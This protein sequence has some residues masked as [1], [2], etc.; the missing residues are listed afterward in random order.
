MDIIARNKTG[1]ISQL[2]LLQE[3]VKRKGFL[4]SL[5]QAITRRVEMEWILCFPIMTSQKILEGLN[6]KSH[7]LS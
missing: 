7:T 1:Q 6:A 4:E 5:N 2:L 3:G